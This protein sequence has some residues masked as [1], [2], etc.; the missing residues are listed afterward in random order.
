MVSVY[1]SEAEQRHLSLIRELGQDKN[2]LDR[3]YAL[4]STLKRWPLVHI[5]LAA[6]VMALAIWHLVLVH[7]YAL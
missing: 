6:G 7:V 2:R 5:P 4:Q 3:H 1:L